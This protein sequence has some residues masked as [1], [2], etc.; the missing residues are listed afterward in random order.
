M[1]PCLAREP[2]RALARAHPSPHEPDRR[3]LAFALLARAFSELFL[4]DAQTIGYLWVPLGG[5]IIFNRVD[6]REAEMIEEI[7]AERG[8][9][10]NYE[11]DRA[12]DLAQNADA[13]VDGSGDGTAS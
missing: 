13:R 1:L 9:D 6:G 8:A 7:E 4:L 11:L 10:P 3:R 12:W 2:E 5:L